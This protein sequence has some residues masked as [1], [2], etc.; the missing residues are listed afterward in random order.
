[1]GI[2]SGAPRA[3]PW[4]TLGV[5]VTLLLVNICITALMNGTNAV[6]PD[7]TIDGL[8]TFVAT[9][10]GFGLFTGDLTVVGWVYSIVN[11]LGWANITSH[12]VGWV[13]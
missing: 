7:F 2:I 9:A 4:R 10:L 3:F 12:I 8:V 5:L 11:I 13:I 1:M 6:F